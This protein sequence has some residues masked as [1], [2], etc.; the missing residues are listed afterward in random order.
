M[1][2]LLLMHLDVVLCDVKGS[3]RRVDELDIIVAAKQRAHRLV[4]LILICADTVAFEHP[5]TPLR[6]PAPIPLRRPS[7]S[8]FPRRKVMPVKDHTSL[9]RQFWYERKLEPTLAFCLRFGTRVPM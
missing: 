3:T 7:A 5:L 9:H 2:V 1:S 6:W 8:L 4:T